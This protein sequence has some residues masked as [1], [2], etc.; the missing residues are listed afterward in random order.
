MA[1]ANRRGAEERELAEPSAGS[2]ATKLGPNAHLIGRAGSRDALLT[3]ALVLDLD[4]LDANIA[5]LAAHA[6]DSGY[7]LRPTVKIHKSVEIARRQLAAGSTV[8]VC[9]ATLGEAEAMVD[10]GITGVLLFS[11]VTVPAKIE[12][13]AALNAR[14]E[15]LTVAVDDAGNVA[16]LAAAARPSGKSLG[17]LV[18]YE[19]GGG[20]TGIADE[21]A[22]VAL[23]RLIAETDGVEFVGV[24]GYVGKHQT[25]V[26]LEE[27]ARATRDR[28]APLARLVRRLVQEGL[29]PAV[30]SGGGTGSHDCEPAAGVLTEVQAGSYVFLDVNYR[31]VVMRRSDPHP[32]T[33]S[34]F[35][36]TTVISAAQQGF[37][38]TDAGNKELDGYRGPLAPQIARGAPEG[39]R[40]TIVGDDL[41][42]VDFAAP[43]HRLA[44]GDAIELVPPHC[45]QTAAMHPVYHCVRGDALVDIWPLVATS[46]W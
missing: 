31:D 26:D 13:L 16:A 42:R 11:S 1:T 19:L 10:G 24:Q 9:C 15:G 27:R 7:R 23:A 4:A 17:L 12:R 18:D 39:A 38:V 29:Q 3:P 22:A 40:Y 14:S 28:S 36:R 5:S 8:G 41:G 32:F 35:V 34:L 30:V 20:R 46:N 45:F 44:L 33:P 21:D 43:H 2:A 37:V 6:S 25:I